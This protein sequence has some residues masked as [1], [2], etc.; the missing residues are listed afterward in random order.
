MHWSDPQSLRTFSTVI[1]WVAIALV[2]FG[3][4][5]QIAKHLV[6]LR[7]RRISR[8]IAD[9]K[10][11]E[12]AKRE[13]E[14]RLKLDESDKKI[15][16]LELEISIDVLAK[17]KGGKPPDISQLIPMGPGGASAELTFIIA[18]GTAPINVKFSGDSGL[19]FTSLE[20]EFTRISY[21]AGAITGSEIFS[22]LPD[23]ITAVR[24][25]RL[26][27]VGLNRP[28]LEETASPIRVSAIALEFY[29][30]G[31]ASF[32][33]RIDRPAQMTIPP[34]PGDIYVMPKVELDVIR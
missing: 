33:A 13:G 25:L 23:K 8:E 30:N 24:D 19:A 32:A 12:Q 29:V 34:G 5:L 26:R 7:E 3:G 16:S 31:R 17:W 22:T 21:R 6:D 28:A 4:C 14:L 9:A 1:Q 2:F 10:D 20:G 15:K 18:G 11:K 27:C